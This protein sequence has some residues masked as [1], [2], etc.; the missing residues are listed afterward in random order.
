VERV[1]TVKIDNPGL[2][3][4]DGTQLTAEPTLARETGPVEGGIDQL[5]RELPWRRIP[6]DRGHR[7]ST[8]NTG[9]LESAG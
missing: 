7:W 5:L 8:S 4:A 2:H 1:V 6:S 3:R 9:L